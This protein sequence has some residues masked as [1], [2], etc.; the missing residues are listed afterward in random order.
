MNEFIPGKEPIEG[1]AL[2][3]ALLSVSIIT[4]NRK[5][6]NLLSLVLDPEELGWLMALGLCSGLIISIAP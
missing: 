2:G 3:Q 1:P 5:E 4:S 6:R